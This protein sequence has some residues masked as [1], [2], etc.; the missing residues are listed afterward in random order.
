MLV[1]PYK[2]PEVGASLT[3]EFCPQKHSSVFAL[4]VLK[5]GH[6][7]LWSVALVQQCQQQQHADI[8]R[9]YHLSQLCDYTDLS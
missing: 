9:V 8:W 6:L 7:C 3:W 5:P 1:L 2:L 4:A